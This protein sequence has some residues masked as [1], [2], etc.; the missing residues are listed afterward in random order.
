MRQR[1]VR[2]GSSKIAWLVAALGVGAAVFLGAVLASRDSRS[3]DKSNRALEATEAEPRPR[4]ERSELGI[5]AENGD[6][7]SPPEVDASV[8]T[9]ATAHSESSQVDPFEGK[10]PGWLPEKP[11][12]QDIRRMK[13]RVLESAI[14]DF[15]DDTKDRFYRYGQ[16]M[17]MS[18]ARIMD[19]AGTATPGES[20]TRRSRHGASGK[21]FSYNGNEYDF[22]DGEFPEYDAF[23]DWMALD[24]KYQE[25]IR[26]QLV[27]TTPEPDLDQNIKSLALER[28]QGA[29]ILLGAGGK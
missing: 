15:Q 18:I 20:S 16:L 4:R 25:S 27:I 12:E 19:E 3:P 6:R 14:A 22:G 9:K 24:R 28:A 17:M 29:L 26:G 11:T 13:V 8:A 5:E 2:F 10:P 21:H 7:Q 1:E 23:V